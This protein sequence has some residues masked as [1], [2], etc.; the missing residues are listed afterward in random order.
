MSIF[1]KLAWLWVLLA[2]VS[3]LQYAVFC[4][5]TDRSGITTCVGVLTFV[6]AVGWTMAALGS[7]V[8]LHEDSPSIPSDSGIPQSESKK[9]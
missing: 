7:I 1:A 3:W 5:T 9:D 4:S 2:M 6:E 8:S